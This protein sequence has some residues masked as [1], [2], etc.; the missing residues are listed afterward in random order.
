[1]R[2][3]CG[4]SPKQEL[5]ASTSGVAGR[6]LGMNSNGVPLVVRR[7]FWDEAEPYLLVTGVSGWHSLETVEFFPSFYNMQTQL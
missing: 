4:R 5:G 1:M 2:L 6:A 3:Q 7:G